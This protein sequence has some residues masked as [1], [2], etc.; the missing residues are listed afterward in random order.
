M[1]KI[2]LITPPIVVLIILYILYN[3][4]FLEDIAYL[5]LASIS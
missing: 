2:L 1:G 3:F 5:N 4:A